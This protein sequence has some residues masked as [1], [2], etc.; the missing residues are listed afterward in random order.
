MH[1]NLSLNDVAMRCAHAATIL[2]RLRVNHA[3][4]A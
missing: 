2:I 4:D 1:G 3:N